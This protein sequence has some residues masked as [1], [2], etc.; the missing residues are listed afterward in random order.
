[1]Y[2]ERRGAPVTFIKNDFV[3]HQARAT[4]IDQSQ[5][6]CN[7]AIENAKRHGFEN[8]IQVLR[9]KLSEESVLDEVEDG[10]DLIVSNPPYVPNG[11]LPELDPEIKL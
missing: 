8:R 2:S 1:M 6:A 4:A 9:H 3:L 7:L 10:L 5:L 11:A